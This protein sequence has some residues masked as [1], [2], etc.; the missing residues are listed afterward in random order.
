MNVFDTEWINEWHKSHASPHEYQTLP[1][2]IISHYI[3]CFNIPLRQFY[4][5]EIIVHSTGLE[6]SIDNFISTLKVKATSLTR[7]GAMGCR[8]GECMG[9]WRDSLIRLPSMSE[10]A[11]S[12][13]DAGKSLPGSGDVCLSRGWSGMWRTNHCPW[14]SSKRL[15]GGFLN[16]SRLKYLDKGWQAVMSEQYIQ[17]SMLWYIN[18]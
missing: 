3:Q 16:L 10:D 4:F 13:E 11:G 15:S 2:S 1:S 12:Q 17:H 8:R 9:A 5:L 14:R 7:T 18:K 6:I